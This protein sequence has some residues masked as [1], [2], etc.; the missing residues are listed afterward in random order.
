MPGIDSQRLR[1]A[2]MY[3]YAPQRDWLIRLR[4]PSR[5]DQATR[6][7]SNPGI[8]AYPA[9]DPQEFRGGPPPSTFTDK[10]RPDASPSRHAGVR[11]R[12]AI[13]P[14]LNP[15]PGGCAAA[16]SLRREDPRHRSRFR[17]DVSRDQMTL[18]RYVIQKP[19][20][21]EPFGPNEVLVDFDGSCP[22]VRRRRQKARLGREISVLPIMTCRPSGDHPRTRS[23]PSSGRTRAAPP[24]AHRG[25]RAS[26][27]ADRRR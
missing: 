9:G 24:T 25:W 17:S 8:G 27:T 19:S 6:R 26:S 4:D 3:R 20:V 22:A 18:A 7:A 16:R 21:E 12:G 2:A 23:R 11:R 14:S 13:E 1:I 5:E 10:D 15:R